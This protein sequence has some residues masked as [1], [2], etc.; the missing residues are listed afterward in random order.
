MP[1]KTRSSKSPSKTK[2]KSITR[3]HS[4]SKLSPSSKTPSIET[5][6]TL[7]YLN[8]AIKKYKRRIREC[9]KAIT[10]K[11]TVADSNF[12]PFDLDAERRRELEQKAMQEAQRR[13]L[14]YDIYGTNYPP[15]N[16]GNP[17]RNYNGGKKSPTPGRNKDDILIK[18]ELKNKMD[19]LED[20]KRKYNKCMMI[21]NNILQSRNYGDRS[22]VVM[23]EPVSSS[24]NRK[25][26][27]NPNVKGISNSKIPTGYVVRDH[28]PSQ[29]QEGQPVRARRPQ[30]PAASRNRNRRGI[31]PLRGR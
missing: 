24:R 20:L 18:N 9:N 11:G 14:Y 21:H 2:T 1:S 8:D 25:K 10:A 30:T 22:S 6:A 15:G 17:L 16:S 19:E 3:T 4:R 27:I 13:Q 31:H 7:N 26:Q 28:M 5:H 29:Q 12:N 23:G